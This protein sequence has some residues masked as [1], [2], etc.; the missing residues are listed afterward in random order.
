MRGKQWKKCQ[1]PKNYEFLKKLK[2][3]TI[4]H[5]IS[6]NLQVAQS[7]NSVL[8]KT[9]FHSFRLRVVPL[10]SSGIVERA[11]RERAWKSPHVRKG[12]TRRGERFFSLPAAC[13]L[14]SREVIFTRDRV[15]LALLSLRNNG[16]LLVVY[17]RLTRNTSSF[18]LI[19]SWLLTTEWNQEAG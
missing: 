11:K 10:F 6:T 12:D 14:F 1:N 3:K 9:P 13:L 2:K 8:N 7:E 5:S 17:I 4:N 18:G 19:K 15:S 16:G